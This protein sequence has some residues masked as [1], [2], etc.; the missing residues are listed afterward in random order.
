MK[1]WLQ[2]LMETGGH[3]G[4]G[5][6]WQGEGQ[7]VLAPQWESGR[8]WELGPDKWQGQLIR[9][10]TSGWC[11]G[12]RKLRRLELSGRGGKGADQGSVKA[13]AEQQ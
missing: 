12:T 5:W 3:T 8:L 4:S 13:I 9:N 11:L 6:P 2:G 7:K 1:E 10:G